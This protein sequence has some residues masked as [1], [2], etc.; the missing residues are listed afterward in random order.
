MPATSSSRNGWRMI[1]RNTGNGRRVCTTSGEC[2]V[3]HGVRLHLVNL[4]TEEIGNPA[5]PEKLRQERDKGEAAAAP[6]SPARSKPLLISLGIISCLLLM[7]AIVALIFAPAVLKMLA[8]PP[9]AATPAVAPSPA[10]P[11]IP[12]KSIAVLPFENL[13]EEKANAYFADG[14][15]DEIL[16]DLAKIADLKVIS[17]TSVMQYRSGVARNLREIGQQLGV[18][19]LLKAVCSARRE[20][21]SERAVDRRPHRRPSLGPDLRS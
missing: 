17:R 20:G 1:W 10:A 7:L 11:A 12:E 21:A 16:T 4:Y 15:Q 9:V 13:S 5:L 2:E 18:A 19:H 8:K 3:K 6:R 14:V